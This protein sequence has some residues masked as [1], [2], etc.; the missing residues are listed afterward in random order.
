[1]IDNEA[2]LVAPFVNAHDALQMSV[3]V[4]AGASPRVWTF[5]AAETDPFAP[6]I[7]TVV[8]LPAGNRALTCS[9]V[10]P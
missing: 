8:P 7:H 6:P 1:V 9:E 3:D 5:G 4:K 2:V 10:N